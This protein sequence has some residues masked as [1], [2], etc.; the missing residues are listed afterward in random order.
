MG[1]IKTRPKIRVQVPSEI[2]P[3]DHFRASVRLDCKRAV[4]VDWVDVTL[5]GEE[6]WAVGSGKNT[7]SQR[8]TLCR[9]TAR[10]CGERELPAGATE[11]AVT[12]PLP[13]DAPPS[14]RS[15]GAFISYTMKVHASV[16]WWPDRRSSFEIL[17]VAPERPSPP[18]EPRR[19]SSD[20]DGPRG[21]EPHAEM[22]LSTDW[23][24]VGDRVTGALALHNTE[25]NRY[26]EVSVALVGT[27]T[28]FRNGAVYTSR[29]HLRYQIRIGAERATDGEMIPFRFRL[30]DDAT[31]DLPARPRPGNL[32]GLMQLEW[33]FELIVGVRWG[34]DLKLR[35]PFRVLPRSDRTTD[36]P[37]RLAPPAVGSDRL[38]DLWTSVGGPLGLRYEMQQLT[39][40]LGE[41]EVR[42]R[43]DH[44][45]RDGIHLVVELTYPE[46]HLGLEVEPSSR[47]QRLVGGGKQIGVEG[48]DKEHYVRA[49]DE[50]Q[51]AAVLGRLV[52]GLKNARL[53][54][55]DDTRMT[56][57]VRDGGTSGA[58]LQRFA[59][60]AIRLGRTLEEVRQALPPPTALS[61]V[62][63]QWQTLA[64]R[65][66]APLERARMRVAG[67]L[68]VAPAEVRV[69]FDEDGEPFCTWLSVQPT[70][71]LDEAHRFRLKADD[72]DPR[73]RITE[74]FEGDAIALLGTIAH[75]ASEVDITP[76]RIAVQLPAPLGLERKPPWISIGDAAPKP[77]DAASVEQRLGRLAQLGQ[78][79]R[80]QAGPY[81]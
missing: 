18:N 64:D 12:I 2:R 8:R 62:V 54:R 52:P 73:A 21:T 63:E 3:G 51:V 53:R 33:S 17:V 47:V 15:G 55:M 69:A 31:P 5:T 61:E 37:S 38:R 39:T 4:T 14:F 23:T 42:I 32:L 81:R 56:V 65:L 22:S 76:E 16:P 46:L 57:Q 13:A 45:G 79:L 43:R 50:G 66:G 34:R 10:L 7:V 41:T 60:G 70:T 67:Q 19:Y 36:A 26:S 40:Q 71:P 77:I 74:R 27:K 48:W 49:R 6:R 75:G 80:G 9:L 28:Y 29:E 44:L 68:G 11:L 59:E 30:P 35:V 20:P 58:R 78:L 25:H 72:A 1:L 24:R